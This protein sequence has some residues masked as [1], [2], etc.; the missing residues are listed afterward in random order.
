MEKRG[1]FVLMF[2]LIILPV[3]SL[4]QEITINFIGA[5]FVLYRGD[6]LN[7]EIGMQKYLLDVEKITKDFVE[8]KLGDNIIKLSKYYPIRKID[9]D[10]DGYYDVVIALKELSNNV[11]LNIKKIKEKDLGWIAFE[12]LP[13]I[14]AIGKVEVD[15]E[16]KSEIVVSDEEIED[17]DVAVNETTDNK[18]L[19]EMLI[20]KEAE[21][22][23]SSQEEKINPIN[24]LTSFS[25]TYFQ[26]IKT[27]IIQIP[28]IGFIISGLIILSV[29]IILMELVFTKK[30]KKVKKKSKKKKGIWEK[31]IDFL[32]EED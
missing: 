3:N 17:I 30:K 18:D 11:V 7:I 21:K 26:K 14:E 16:E 2:L 32:L 9:V 1:I 6:V 10:V 22:R 29:I 15:E 12:D 25:K 13:L 28:Y 31:I 5:D 24:N 27:A 4:D 23:E 20:K 19:F 8:I